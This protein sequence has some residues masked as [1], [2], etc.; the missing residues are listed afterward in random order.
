MSTELIALRT[1][2]ERVV[3]ELEPELFD[4]VDAAALVEQFT[5]IERLGAAG[6][7]LMA[8]RV[9]ESN[10][11]RREGHRSA[12]HWMATTTGTTV[13]QAVGTLEVARS[14]RELPST[15]AAFRSG[16]LSETQA[17]EVAAA[18]VTDPGAESALLDAACSETVGRLREH[19]WA[20]RP[21]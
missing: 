11:W 1:S 6:K 3:A 16:Q 10:V 19:A 18:A 7:A 4:G 21:R 8:R 2:L 17:R 12:A 14:L 20:C 9:E 5:A 15:D 13:G